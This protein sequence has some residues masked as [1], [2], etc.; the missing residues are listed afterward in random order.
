[1]ITNEFFPAVMRVVLT[2]QEDVLP[3]F[4]EVITRLNS[5]LIEVSKNPKNPV[6][7]H[8]LFETIAAVIKNVSTKGPEA[9]MTFEKLLFEPF[10]FILSSD[11]QGK[12]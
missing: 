4:T 12:Q 11:V 5:I 2:A 6:F 8:Y 9:V 10:Q 3:F 7:N 1:M